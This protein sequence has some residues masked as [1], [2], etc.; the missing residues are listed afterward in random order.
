MD[1]CDKTMKGKK[2]EDFK[3]CPSYNE[4]LNLRN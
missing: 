3:K 1:K 2:E 4:I